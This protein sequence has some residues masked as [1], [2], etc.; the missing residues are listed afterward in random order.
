MA[1]QKRRRDDPEHYRALGCVVANEFSDPPKSRYLA[2]FCGIVLGDGAVSESQLQIT[3]N[4]IVDRS[5]V[6]YVGALILE[7]FGY[8]PSIYARKN[9]N[10]TVLVITGVKFIQLLQSL[11]LQIGDKVRN[12]VDVPLWIKANSEFSRWCVRGLMDTDGGIFQHHYKVNG[13]QYEYLKTCFSNLSQ[14]LRHFVYN[15][16]MVNGLH[17][18]L[19]GMNHVW[20]YSESETC[21][22]MRSIGSSNERLL[23]KFT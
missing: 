22:Y 4:S 6:Q 14:P 16:L 1:S 15:T 20:L 11:G 10:A 18:K 8:T 3:L 9:C 2:E 13:K 17:P 21:K 19:R 23:S 7:L 5:Y 12:Q